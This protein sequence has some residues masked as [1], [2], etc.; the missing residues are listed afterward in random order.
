[1]ALILVTV[2]F[3]AVSS[4]AAAGDPA[5]AADDKS[6]ET[7]K[8]GRL[9]VHFIDVGQADAA[10]L[11]DGKGAVLIDGGNA[12]DG[13]LV[14]SCIKNAGV[15][16]L[17]LVIGTHPHEDHIGGL[18]DVLKSV[19]ASV[20]TLP[21]KRSGTAAWRNL[22]SAIKSAG[23]KRVTAKAGDE[24]DIGD[25][26]IVLV[27][28][29]KT[30][31]GDSSEDLNNMSVICKVMYG[32]TSFLFTGDAEREAESDVLA[33]GA[34]ISCD[35]L[36]VPHH[37]SGSSSSYVFL[38]EANP[39]IAVISCGKDNDY[40]HPHEEVLSRYN[41]LGAEVIRTDRLGTAVVSSDGK[42][43]TADKKGDLP[44]KPHT[45]AAGLGEA[46]YAAYVGNLRSKV[47][48]APDCTGLPAE[49]NRTTFDERDDALD[50]GYR[51]CGRCNP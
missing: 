6:K 28:P 50:A 48:H 7:G 24:Y 36:K 19:K 10:L 30:Y 8:E 25:M 3:L 43:V 51:P 14:V 38:R 13:P 42:T 31:K 26:H 1:M 44:E 21:N 34:D 15:K 27:A 12:M 41:D 32:D 4:C 11:T 17:D 39:K 20:I 9:D 40:G 33:S 49:K 23:V 5:G 16:K 47:F 37:G 2:L 18:S 29:V 22:L 46:E 45:D 35:V